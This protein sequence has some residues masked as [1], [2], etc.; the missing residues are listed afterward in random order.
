M[1]LYSQKDY[2]AA[3]NSNKKKGKNLI[4]QLLNKLIL[5][6]ILF[7]EK[8]HKNLEMVK[9]VCLAYQVSNNKIDLIL[10]L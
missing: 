6:L 9:K 4:N 1:K 5:S 8:I 10:V 7:T 2:V 3:L